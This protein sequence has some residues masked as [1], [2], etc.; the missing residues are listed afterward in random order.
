MADLFVVS[1]LAVAGNSGFRGLDNDFG[2]RGPLAGFSH[3]GV[4]H[5]LHFFRD[6]RDETKRQKNYSYAS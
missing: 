2:A 4:F 3:S 5:T 1:M 6:A